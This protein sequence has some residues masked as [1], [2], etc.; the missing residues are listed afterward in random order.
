[1][2]NADDERPPGGP[3]AG[4][5]PEGAEETVALPSPTPA[6]GAP[7]PRVTFRSGDV[8]AA[9]FRIVRFVARGAVGE[10][11]EAEDMNLGGRVALKSLRP[12]VALDQDGIE[13]FRREILLARKVTHPN[14]CRIF[15]IGHHVGPEGEVDFLTMEFVPGETLSQLLHRQGR[16][17][18]KEALPIAIQM[19]RAL[20]AAHE[21][22]VIHRDFKSGNV[23]LVSSSGSGGPRAVVTDFGFARGVAK[24]DEHSLTLSGTTVGTP[25]YMAPEQVEG[26]EVTPATDVYALGVVLYEMVAGKRP[27]TG[28]TPFSTAVKRLRET[29]SSPRAYVPDLDAV[30][31]AVILRCLERNPKDRFASPDDVV[32]ALAGDAGTARRFSTRRLARRRWARATAALAA[33]L[34]L[35][36]VVVFLRRRGAPAPT[37][38]DAGMRRSIA[39]LGF[40]NLGPPGDAWLSTAVAEMLTTELS[41]GERL[42]TVAGEEIARVKRGLSLADAET[43]SK[44]TLEKIRGA[45]H[46]DLVVVGSYISIGEG[47]SSQLRLD[48]RVQ[49][50]TVGETLASVGETGSSAQLFALVSQAA[51]DLRPKL[52]LLPL[53]PADKGGVQASLPSTPE[54]YPLY[55]RGLERLRAFDARG[56]RELFEQS[57]ER[58]PDFALAYAALAE[59]WDTL[60]YDAKAREAAS[61]AYERSKGLTRQERLSVEGRLRALTRDYARSI[62]VY[63]TLW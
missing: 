62:E 15:D 23:L 43:Y 8:V 53:S 13:R 3:E 34:L 41:A 29:P 24:D 45:L 35:V 26:G 56:A 59:A 25:A 31:E 55:A 44:E 61:M 57:I 30:W 46:A 36:L 6:R 20:S 2:T 52:G 47:P 58:C 63:K 48:V 54:A 17:T 49:D 42:R 21:A 10:V 14:V 18:T 19:A 60:G 9:R 32:T 22:G 40:R 5:V 27:F 7:T 50:A 28:D 4:G 16:L 33:S 12:E 11:Y 38:S 51:A 1:M 39:V 37:P